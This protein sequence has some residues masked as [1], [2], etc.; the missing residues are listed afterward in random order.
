MMIINISAD[1]YSAVSPESLHM[2]T[3]GSYSTKL[4]TTPRHPDNAAQ[5]SA[6]TS[7]WSAIL[8]IGF[9]AI[10]NLYNNTLTLVQ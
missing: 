8:V 1:T 3:S 9:W 10:K 2:F 6:T 4:L 7:L 5:C